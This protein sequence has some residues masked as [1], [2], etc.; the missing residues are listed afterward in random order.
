MTLTALGRTAGSLE[1]GVWEGARRGEW[2]YFQKSLVLLQTDD[3]AK[4]K[5]SGGTAGSK[6][7]AKEAG[8]SINK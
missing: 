7:R 5:T 8:A 3:Y 4:S 1:A 6:K 2:I